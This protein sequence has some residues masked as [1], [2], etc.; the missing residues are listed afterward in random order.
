LGQGPVLPDALRGRA[1]ALFTAVTAATRDGVAILGPSG[2]LLLWNA[3]AVAITGWSQAEAASHDLAQLVRAGGALTEIREGMWVEVRKSTLDAGG[4]VFTLVLFTD[5]THQLRLLDTKQQLRGLGLIDRI[6][7]LPGRELAMV[8]LDNAIALA[9]RDKRSVGVLAL[10]L[11]RFRELRATEEGAVVE[12]TLRQL[13]KRLTAFVRTSDVSSRLSDDTFLVV[14]TAMTEI[15]DA[16]VV[17]VRLLL[18]MAEP[19]DVVGKMRTLHCSIGVAEAPRDAEQG[20]TLL[21]AALGAADRAQVLGG[22]QFCV[23]GD[24][25]PA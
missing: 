17:A 21:G 16:K 13:A 6:T 19:F 12:E 8:H 25:E 23:A 22:G 3:S 15:N 1:A 20:A 24:R 14:L 18:A 10:K 4:A 7:S 9:K 11:D 2:E 5:S